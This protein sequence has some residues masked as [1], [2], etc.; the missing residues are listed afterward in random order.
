[1]NASVP[2]AQP[3]GMRRAT[4]LG[5]GSVTRQVL[6]NGLVVLVYPNPAIP[7]VSVRLSV[8]AGAIYDPPNLSGRAAFTAGALRRGTRRHSF[9]E[10]NE[11]TEE[12]GLSVGVDSGYHLLDVGGRGLREDAGFLMDT[13]AE[14]LREPAF[15]DE[16]IERMRGQW[17]TGLLE[18]EDDTRSKAEELF[19]QTAYPADHPYSRDPGGTLESIRALTRADLEEHYAGYVRPEGGIV[20]IVGDTTAEAGVALVE[21]TLGDWRVAGPPPAFAVP[22]A[23]PPA[24][25]RDVAHVIAG[26]TQNDL[27]LGFP[28]IR[29]TDPDYYALEMAN[30]ILGR[31]GLYG[32][33]GKSVREEQGL[34]YY[35]I[36]GLEAGFGPGP[37][38]VRAGVNPTNV[39]RAVRSILAE[40]ERIR[41]EPVTAQELASGQRFL[42]GTLP[43]RLETNA[44]I[45]RQIAE[46][47]L[48]DLGWN[49]IQRFPEIINALTVADVQRVAQTYLH[50]DQYVLAVAGPE[51]PAADATPAPG[52]APA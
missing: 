35:A 8:R 7:A 39:G 31:L 48:F 11:I 46:I 27:V 38:A 1:M 50:A 13:V 3:D 26:K 32:R 22:D 16:E 33:L 40:I 30:L 29:R 36:S 14:V 23:P 19:R 20:V 6:A 34:A 42:T 28:G 2:A 52:P 41:A 18:Q 24:G 44:G 47:E 9:T 4:A 15:P 21:R 25:V 45:A 49:Y 17:L 37:W 5:P 43:L 10:L 51:L 12:R